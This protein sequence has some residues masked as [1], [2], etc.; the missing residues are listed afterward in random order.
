MAFPNSSQNSSQSHIVAV[1]IGSNLGN[2]FN[3]LCTGIRQLKE[4][5]LTSFK[6]SRI[7]ETQAVDCQE[8]L[9]FLNAV[10]AFHTHLAPDHLLRVLLTIEEHI[11]RERPYPNAPRVLDLDLLLWGQNI[12]DLPNLTIPHP[13]MH[14]RRFVLEPLN[15]LVPTWNHPLVNK[16]VTRLLADLDPQ[17]GASEIKELETSWPCDLI[18]FA[19]AI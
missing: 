18:G 11:G 16:S 7:Y 3:Y 19:K 15:E 4:L 13:R 2:R 1:S 6:L 12:I 5:P 10:C 17:N 8:P 9:P 14:L